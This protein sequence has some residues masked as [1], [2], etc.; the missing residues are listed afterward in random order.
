MKLLAIALLAAVSLDPS[1]VAPDI[2]QRL[3]RFQKVEMPFTYAG[4][5]AR[6]R[7]VID[8]MIAACRDL[9]NIYWRQNNPEDVA[10][11]NSLAGATDPKLRDARRD[12]WINGS[13]F[14]LHTH[15][16]PYMVNE[17]FP[18]GRNLLPKGL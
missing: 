2:A 1:Q 4:M 15:T 3:A 5:S 13:R 11:Y 9:E 7:R 17:P 14:V 16:E 12:L 8:E 6:E 18:P 10:L